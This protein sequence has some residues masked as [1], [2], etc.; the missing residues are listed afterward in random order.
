MIALHPFTTVLIRAAQDPGCLVGLPLPKWQALLQVAKSSNLIGR[1]SLGAR[2][3]RVWCHV[4]EQVKPHLL[5]AYLL[6]CH[7]RDAIRWEIGHI[8]HALTPLNQPVVLLKGAAYAA[9]GLTAGR[10]RL[11][12]DV[13]V[14]VPQAT[15]RQAEALLIQHG[16]SMGSIDPYDER[17]YRQWMHELPPMTH[18]MRGTVI[19]LHHNLLPITAKWAPQPGLFLNDS[20]ALPASQLRVLLAEDRVIHSATHLFH[21]GELKNGLRDLFDLDAL[22]REGLATDPGFLERVA[23]R[24]VAQGLVWPVQM[25]FRYTQGLLGTPGSEPANRALESAPGAIRWRWFW[26]DFLY[27]RGLQP[28]HPLTASWSSAL[29]R[30]LVYLRSHALRM[31]ADKLFRHLAR[32]AFVRLYKNTSRVE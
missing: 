31:P 2:T 8:E 16:W 9:A 4:P 6:T 21:E 28:Q 17:Y 29:A 25:A 23:S 12:G 3:P 22:L 18:R 27:L 30:G 20:V 24:A 15:M 26:F 19:D 7:Q 1:L 14:L 13:D 10:G 32:K 5:S 11:F